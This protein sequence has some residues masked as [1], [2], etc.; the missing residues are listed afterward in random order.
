MVDNVEVS[1]VIPVYNEEQNLP[2]LMERLLPVMQG[3]GK[4]F[5]IVLIDDGSADN[6]LVLLKGFAKYEHVK[7]IELTRFSINSWRIQITL[8]RSSKIT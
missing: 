6:S 2:L 1:V 8:I 7:I 5:E 3:T 4:S